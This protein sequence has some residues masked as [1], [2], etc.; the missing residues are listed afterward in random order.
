[1]LC[2]PSQTAF[3]VCQKQQSTCVLNH[4]ETLTYNFSPYISPFFTISVENLIHISQSKPVTYVLEC[5][6]LSVSQEAVLDRVTVVVAKWLTCLCCVTVW[7]CL[8]PV[9]RCF[10]FHPPS[11][12]PTHPGFSGT[13]CLHLCWNFLFP[14]SWSK[15]RR[16]H[17]E[18]DEI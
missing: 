3:P 2:V 7:T 1:M 11:H 17:R 18:K 6:C 8:E 16:P 14:P 9:Q 15:L 5:E 12:L 13:C 4:F 10:P